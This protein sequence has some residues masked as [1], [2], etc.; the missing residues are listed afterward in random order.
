MF[1]WIRSD[2]CGLVSASLVATFTSDSIPHC[3][4]D[5]VTDCIPHFI[6]PICHLNG[7]PASMV[8]LMIA[9]VILL[10]FFLSAIIIFEQVGIYPS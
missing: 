6:C 5:V 3:C 1:W 7:Y 4:V 9:F 8:D 10:I 2:A